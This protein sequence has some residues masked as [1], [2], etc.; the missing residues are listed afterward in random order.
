MKPT[1]LGTT[2]KQLETF[3]AGINNSTVT[4]ATVLVS[5]GGRLGV[6]HSAAG[7][8]RN[9]MPMDK[10][11]EAIMQ[12]RPVTFIY[13]SDP[14]NTRQYGLVA[15]QVRGVYPELVTYDD[16]GE[17]QSV[18]YEQLIPMLLNELQKQTTKSVQQE[19]KLDLLQQQISELKQVIQTVNRN[20]NLADAS[21]IY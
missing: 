7:F 19:R 16:Q 18:R 17:L 21:S 5:S 14:S 10:S 4:G 8:K 15:E 1:C 9:I 20:H 12:L 11:S 6:A 2:G 13:K 3:V